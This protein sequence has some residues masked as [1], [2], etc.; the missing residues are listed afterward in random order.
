MKVLSLLALVSGALG[1]IRVHFDVVK[2]GSLGDYFRYNIEIFDNNDFY[3]K[4]V[5]ELEAKYFEIWEASCCNEKYCYTFETYGYYG[6]LGLVR[7]YEFATVQQLQQELQNQRHEIQS[8]RETVQHLQIQSQNQP[9]H[10]LRLPDPPRFDGKPYSLRTWLPSIRA[11]L[12]ADQLSGA[13][14]FEYIWDRLEQP[15]QAFILHLRQSSDEDRSWDPEDIFSYF[16]RLCHNP[17]EQQEAIQRFCT[18]RQKDDEFFIAYLARFERLSFEAGANKWPDALLSQDPQRLSQGPRAT[19][20]NQLSPRS[21]F[22]S[23]DSLACEKLSRAGAN[24]PPYQNSP[25]LQRWHANHSDVKASKKAKLLLVEELMLK[26]PA[27]PDLPGF[28]L[29]RPGQLAL[30]HLPIHEGW[31]CLTCSYTCLATRTIERHQQNQ[32]EERR[33][34]PGRR[35]KVEA[36]V[37]PNWKKVSCQRLFVQ[38][39][40]SQYFAVVSPA[41]VKEEEDIIRRQAMAAK[42]PEAEYIRTQIDKA[43]EQ[44]EKETRALEDTILDNAAPTEVSPWLEMTHWPKYLHGYSFIEV[45]RLANPANLASEPLLVE[46]SDSLDRIVEQAHTSI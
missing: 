18:V 15:Q 46:F 29:P 3:C 21:S 35:T 40:K 16:H 42:L 31:S 33:R 10:R 6:Q 26:H 43:L 22:S 41:E 44:G 1:C 20:L 45:A 11:K 9:A 5:R 13:S 25:L 8:L 38:G 23:A 7:K 39:C 14:A 27:N 37:E 12:R 32:H 34:R 19:W 17:R 28:Q 24:A 30:P 36:L 4:N 2:T